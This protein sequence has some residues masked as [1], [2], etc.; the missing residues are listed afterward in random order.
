MKKEYDL[1]ALEALPI[2]EVIIAAQAGDYPKDRKPGNRIFNMHCRGSGHKNGD[3]HPS[4]TVWTDMNICKCQSQGC[5]SG[6]PISV[7]KQLKGGF[8]EG[9]KWLHETFGISYL[10]G[11]KV[12]RKPIVVEKRQEQKI[13]YLRLDRE[14]NVVSVQLEKFMPRYMDMDAERQLKMLYTYIYRFSLTTEQSEKIAYY[15]GRGIVDSVYMEK[16]GFLKGS[17]MKG[18]VSSIK[19][20][21][22]IEDLIRF[23]LVDET[24][25]WK[26]YSKA[27]FTVVP[28]MD[29]YDDMVNGF[30]L[31]RIDK[32][33][34]GM[35][36]YQIS[37]SDVSMPLP[38]AISKSLLMNEQPIYITEGHVDGLSLGKPFI[39]IPGIYGYKEEWLSLLKSK[40]VIIALDQDEP[41]RKSIYGE[42]TVYHENGARES[43]VA[44]DKGKA[45]V[46][47]LTC[48]YHKKEGLMLKVLKAGAKSVKVLTWNPALGGDIN[49][50][51]ENGNLD[52][53][54]T[55]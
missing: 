4:L 24:K 39:A 5:I 41:A 23:K 35:K 48:D 10:D 2:D 28:F 17:Q 53:V 44:D 1:E 46:E 14:R 22:P 20:L 19:K 42:Y 30:M 36:E 54:L 11:T 49:E 34:S 51:L 50:L 6:N 29:L 25:K 38:F 7:A 9:C 15:K 37:T 45:Y 21:F 43:V 33:E 32:T 31:R 18:L 52:R 3:K 13:E 26:Y 27:G 16:I 40:D 8:K 55:S 12:E 47:D